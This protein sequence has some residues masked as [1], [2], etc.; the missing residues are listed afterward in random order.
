MCDRGM[1]RRVDIQGF[2]FQSTTE[3]RALLSPVIPLLPVQIRETWQESSALNLP[4]YVC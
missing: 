4:V 2:P 3:I 1:G